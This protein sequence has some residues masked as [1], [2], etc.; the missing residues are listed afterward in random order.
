MV[1]AIAFP[2]ISTYLLDSTGKKIA[3]LDDVVRELGLDNVTTVHARAEDVAH[4]PRYRNAFDLISARAVTT[5]PALLEL[6]LPMLRV[7]GTMLLP[8]GAEIDEELDAGHRAAEILRGEIVS[9]ELLPDA[10]SNVD[11]RLVIA[12]KLATTPSTYPRRSGMP[13]KNPLGQ[14]PRAKAGK[15]GESS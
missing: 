4:Q 3:F 5:L 12:R 10:G 6:S 7:N 8:K 11:T 13:S 14:A 1:L 15:Q 9:A 2:E